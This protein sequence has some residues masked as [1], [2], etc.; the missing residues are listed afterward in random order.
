MRSLVCN[1]AKA[2]TYAWVIAV[3]LILGGKKVLSL[4]NLPHAILGTVK[5]TRP[6]GCTLCPLGLIA[7]V[8]WEGVFIFNFFIEIY[9][10]CLLFVFAIVVQSSKSMKGKQCLS[11]VTFCDSEPVIQFQVSE[12]YP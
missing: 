2:S 1:F 6:L 9:F 4:F 11:A 8:W 5:T 3:M 12:V 7:P 10:I